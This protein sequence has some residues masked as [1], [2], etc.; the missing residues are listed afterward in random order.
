MNSIKHYFVNSHAGA[1]KTHAVHDFICR[2][3]EKYFAIATQ[4]NKL[5]SQQCAD[6][7]ALGRDAHVISLQEEKTN[8]TKRFNRACRDYPHIVQI[9]NQ[10]VALQSLDSTHE[11]HLIVDEY[12]SP[13]EKIKIREDLEI[14]QRT[15]SEIFCT[16]RGMKQDG[17]VELTSNSAVAEIAGDSAKSVSMLKN[18]DGL[19]RVC[20]YIESPHWQVII[21]KEAFERLASYRGSQ[22]SGEG[23]FFALKI[24]AVLLP[25]VLANYA[26]VTFTGANFYRSKLF[27]CWRSMV[28]FEP[29]PEIRASRYE[30]FSHKEGKIKVYHLSE[31]PVS[32]ARLE[33]IGY[34][35]VIA[36]I[37]KIVEATYPSRSYIYTLNA[38]AGDIW[39]GAN[40]TRVSPNPM[41]L[42]EYM[43]VNMAVHAATLNPGKDDVA[44][45]RTFFDVSEHELMEAQAYEMQYQFVTRTSI[46]DGKPAS[47]SEEVVLIVLDRR[48]ADALCAVL[49]V[50]KP[51]CELYIP[52]LSSQQK[53]PRKTRSDKKPPKS[54]EQQRAD[55]AERQ[56]RYRATK[57][58]IVPGAPQASIHVTNL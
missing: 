3:K 18:L 21:E 8:C 52:A 6:L 5:S 13:V 14:G 36:S 40:G 57:R 19:R 50:E 32:M 30:D 58:G 17:Y 54:L 44:F 27:Y 49:G 53:A 26:S 11:H 34:K 23:K 55:D 7:N 41:G 16:M 12:P 51:S 29:H 28:D 37:A 38:K 24:Y 48:S 20:R 39:P 2:N 10:G 43:Q 56:R 46:R 35:S 33:R 22:Q 9:V 42:N 47:Q 31:A 15:Y 25:T 1:G 45:W 4:T